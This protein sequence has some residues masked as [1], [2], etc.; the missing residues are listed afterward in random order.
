MDIKIGKTK[1]SLME[2]D[3]TEVTA[4]AIVNAANNRLWMGGGVAGAIK[5]KG[6]KIIEE[7]ALRLGPIPIGEAVATSAGKLNAKYV[8][9]AA[10]MGTDLKT[11]EEKIKN[12]TLN[13]LKRADELKIKSIAFPSI[14]TGVGGFPTDKAA[15]IMLSATIEHIKGVTSLKNVIFVLYGNSAYEAFEKVLAGIKD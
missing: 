3:I 1:I 9:H 13:S 5:R 6:G 11:D 14:G 12:A 7:E 8:I 4:D 15:E 10:G 2:G